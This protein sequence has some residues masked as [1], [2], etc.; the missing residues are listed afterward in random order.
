[1]RF[2]LK[3][4]LLSCSILIII[5]F[6]FTGSVNAKNKVAVPDVGEMFYAPHFKRAITK[7]GYNPHKIKTRDHLIDSKKIFT[8]NVKNG[9]KLG[10][11]FSRTISY[12]SKTD[13]FA[14]VVSRVSGTGIYT[15]LNSDPQK[16]AFNG[17]FR[18]DG[19]PES[20]GSVEIR[21]EGKTNIYNGKPYTN[22]DGSGL[23]YNSLIWGTPP[24]K[25]KSGDTWTVTIPQPWELGGSGTQ[26]ITVLDIDEKNNTIMLK[27]EGTS[28]GF[29]DHD[30][31]NVGI[32][33]DGKTI[34]MDIT[35]GQSHW[36]GYTIFKN[37]L[38]ISDELLVTRPVTLTSDN[39]KFEALERE[40]ILLN[41][42]PAP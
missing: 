7:K 10:N 23:M 35:P 20:H 22:T 4:I 27:R 16:P 11:I 33:K 39:F 34:K 18:Y 2:R 40:Y 3:E 38:V 5:P 17:E 36:I 6:G 14:E 41:A 28:E 8:L 30:A 15:V 29:Y 12:K 25:I 37:G 1:M 19:R 24:D 21:D 26:T 9:E 31:K 13:S 42:M 32:I